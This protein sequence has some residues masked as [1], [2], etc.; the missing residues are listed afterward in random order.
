MWQLTTS[1]KFQCQDFT[2]QLQAIFLSF[3]AKLIKLGS[4]HNIINVRPTWEIIVV[5]WGME[6]NGDHIIKKEPA[7]IFLHRKCPQLYHYIHIKN[8]KPRAENKQT[9]LSCGLINHTWDA[10]SKGLFEYRRQE[11]T[12]VYLAYQG[13]L[14]FERMLLTWC[15]LGYVTDWAKIP[16]SGMCV[17][18]SFRVS[19]SE[20]QD[21]NLL[22]SYL[23]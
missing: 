3:Y 20:K 1:F 10:C 8:P 7:T 9:I 21:R 18:C 16:T 6:T 12:S 15:T 22:S 13:M 14:G 5:K 23:T 17:P 2:L 11:P 4:Y 19:T